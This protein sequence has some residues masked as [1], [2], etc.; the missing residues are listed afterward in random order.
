MRV[1]RAPARRRWPDGPAGL[2]CDF[3]I[4]LAYAAKQLFRLQPIGR[5]D[6]SGTG[7]IIFSALRRRERHVRAVNLIANSVKRCGRLVQRASFSCQPL[8]IFRLLRGFHQHE[9]GD[10]RG[11]QQ[12]LKRIEQPRLQ[13]AREGGGRMREFSLSK[14]RP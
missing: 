8:Q 12:L 4:K 13:I 9:G 6:R 10:C 14:Q 1:V 3:T 11:V 5:H 7:K 2:E